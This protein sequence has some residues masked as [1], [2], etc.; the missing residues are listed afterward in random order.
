MFIAVLFIVVK[1]GWRMDGLIHFEKVEYHS[2]VRS[3]EPLYM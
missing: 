2:A 3:N 1:S